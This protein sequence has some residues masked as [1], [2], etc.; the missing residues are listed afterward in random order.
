VDLLRER[1]AQLVQRRLTAI[2]L[3]LRFGERGQRV[4]RQEQRAALFLGDVEHFHFH[5]GVD[6]AAQVAV[7]QLEPAVGQLADEQAAGK[8]D[9]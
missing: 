5:I 9:P 4:D 7:D 8:A 6:V 3:L 2:E 1:L